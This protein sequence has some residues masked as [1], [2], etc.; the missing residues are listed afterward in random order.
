[1]KAKKLREKRHLII[2]CLDY[3]CFSPPKYVNLDISLFIFIEYEMCPS[4]FYGGYV[5]LA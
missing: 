5:A 1:M 2:F 3:F 4:L